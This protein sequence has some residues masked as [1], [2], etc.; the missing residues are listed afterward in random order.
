MVRASLLHFLSYCRGVLFA[1]SLQFCTFFKKLV[2]ENSRILDKLLLIS[3]KTSLIVYMS[4]FALLIILDYTIIARNKYYYGMAVTMTDLS[5][6]FG[7]A[8]CALTIVKF[9]KWYHQDR[10]FRILG[11]IITIS[12]LFALMVFSISYFS[13]NPNDLSLKIK[14][15]RDRI[16]NNDEKH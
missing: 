3:S 9:L 12:A 1:L 10:E 4:I 8:F 6:L 14:T 7:L 15:W 13:V 5:Y 2:S 16:H 11:Y